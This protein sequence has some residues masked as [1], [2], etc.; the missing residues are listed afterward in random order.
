MLRTSCYSFFRSWDEHKIRAMAAAAK[1]KYFNYNR[2]I[3]KSGQLVKELLIIRK[4]IVKIIKSVPKNL[5]LTSDEHVEVGLDGK[6]KSR[7]RGGSPGQVSELVLG[8]GGSGMGD[9]FLSQKLADSDESLD[10][11]SVLSMDS[12]FSI[13]TPAFGHTEPTFGYSER[14]PSFPTRFPQ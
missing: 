8:Q 9:V 1:V 7:S 13:Q 5:L 3:I 10:S 12:L 4:G 14:F 6:V 11:S 2:K